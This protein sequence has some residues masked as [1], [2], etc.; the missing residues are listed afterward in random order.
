MSSTARWKSAETRT[1]FPR[2]RCR[3]RSACEGPDSTLDPGY[4]R[5]RAGRTSAG[6]LHRAR[7]RSARPKRARERAADDLVGDS[8]SPRWAALV[9]RRRKHGCKNVARPVDERAAGIAAADLAAER[10]HL[11]LNGA[12][13]VGVLADHRLGASDPCG[14]NAE[15]A[16]LR[17]AE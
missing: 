14:R 13:A 6:C 3:R 11:T 1:G 10:R 17:I 5:S 16:V 15:G 8:Q 12:P 4:R 9:L 7:S 2:G